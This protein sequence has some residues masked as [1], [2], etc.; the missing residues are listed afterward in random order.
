ML[1]KETMTEESA[2]I[3]KA[4]KNMSAK[5]LFTISG[6][7]KATE[8]TYL[9]NPYDAPK[10][11]ATRNMPIKIKKAAFKSSAIFKDETLFLKD[12][13]EILRRYFIALLT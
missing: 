8:L 7:A 13:N 1:E 11:A 2:V 12:R 6:P 10:I 4:V 9:K 3:I 5:S